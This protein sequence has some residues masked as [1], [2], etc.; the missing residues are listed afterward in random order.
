MFVGIET[1]AGTDVEDAEPREPVFPL[2]VELPALILHIRVEHAL[3]TAFPVDG[4]N[5]SSVEP[6]RE[7][8]TNHRGKASV[9]GG[10]AVLEHDSFVAGDTLMI[11]NTALDVEPVEEHDIVEYL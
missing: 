3:D 9:L 1:T 5:R 10:L 4:D 6:R 8:Q 11:H 7:F 2:G